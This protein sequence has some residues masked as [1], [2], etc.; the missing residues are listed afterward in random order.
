MK[1]EV[2][3]LDPETNPK[4]KEI[5]DLLLLA[6]YFRTRI[7]FIMLFNK[8]IIEFILNIKCIE[9]VNNII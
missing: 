5:L 3:N 6:G 4:I 9:L 7:P 2:I 8:V 1:G